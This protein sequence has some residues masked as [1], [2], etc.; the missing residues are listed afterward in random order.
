[1]RSRMCW[2]I[3]RRLRPMHAWRRSTGA[4]VWENASCT[5]QNAR[6]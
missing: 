6:C 2:R 1:M 3:P 4:A 5:S